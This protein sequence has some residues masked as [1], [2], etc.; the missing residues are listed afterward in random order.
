MYKIYKC[1][2]QQFFTSIK[3]IVYNKNKNINDNDDDDDDNK[4]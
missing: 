3:I 1:M 4:I 2:K